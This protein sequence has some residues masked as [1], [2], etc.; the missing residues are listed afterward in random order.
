VLWGRGWQKNTDLRTSGGSHGLLI[1]SCDVI[2]VSE[3]FHASTIQRVTSVLQGSKPLI[4]GCE[5]K[6]RRLFHRVVFPVAI[7]HNFWHSSGCWSRVSVV[8]PRLTDRQ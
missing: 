3:L 7:C 2:K 6:S 1:I 5:V 8:M 4:R